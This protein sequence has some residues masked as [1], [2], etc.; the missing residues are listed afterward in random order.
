[1]ILPATR[2]EQASACL[3][4]AEK[5]RLNLLAVARR[6][7]GSHDEGMDLFQQTCLN[8]HDAIQRNGFAGG[9]YEFY[10]LISLKNLHYKEKKQRLR[11]VSIDA[12]V[13]HGA[14]D[15]HGEEERSSLTFVPGQYLAAAE[16][17]LSGAAELAEQ[18]MQEVRQQ[19]SPADRLALRLH[20]DGYSTRQIAELTGQGHHLGVHRQLTR[21][22]SYLRHTFRQAWLA[23][24]E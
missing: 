16:P 1:M 11:F 9:R 23:L 4:A 5:H 19:F 15:Q 12:E 18:L 6:L 22:K 20:L 17:E 7:T 2:E 21:L 24:A 14:A 10:L 13:G 3:E 8:C